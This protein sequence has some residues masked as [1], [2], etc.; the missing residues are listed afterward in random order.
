M[1]KA[2]PASLTHTTRSPPKITCVRPACNQWPHTDE[3]LVPP[4]KRGGIAEGWQAIQQCCAI[5][6]RSAA[7]RSG[8]GGAA[9][10][11]S[12]GR[13]APSAGWAA[14]QQHQQ[15]QQEQQQRPWL[16]AWGT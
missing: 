16:S 6:A 9:T 14:Q 13:T 11:A 2:Q 12:S 10:R 1:C 15:Q 7:T 5:A 3:S 8:A 4:F